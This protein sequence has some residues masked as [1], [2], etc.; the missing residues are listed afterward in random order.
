[1]SPLELRRGAAGVV[2]VGHRGAAALGPENSLEAIQIAAAHSLDAVEL[3]VHPRGDGPLVLAHGP[4]V[5]AD[6]PLLDD[7]LA[8]AA[9]LGLAVQLDVKLPGAEA[10]V[11]E[12]LRGAR[13]LE[14]SFVSSFAPP[15]LHAFA[16]LAPELPRSFTYPE[17]RLGVSERRLL[18][19]A[20]RPG[21]AVLRAMLP[22]RLPRLLRAVDARAATLNWAVVTPAAVAACHAA[23]AA[24]YVWTVNDPA[25][26]KR[27]V[28]SNIDGIIGDDP[29]ILAGPLA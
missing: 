9:R 19:P 5:P 16:A 8:L 2:R 27:L 4:A 28:A 17:D 14:R 13:L 15:I 29:R 11:V 21:L 20:V 22:R 26:V 6:A 24:V 1:V 18:R 3:D 25:L 7:A 10:G 23:G 12:A